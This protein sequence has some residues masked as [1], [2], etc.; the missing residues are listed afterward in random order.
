LKGKMPSEDLTEK[1]LKKTEAIVYSMTPQERVRPETINGSRRR[2]IAVGSGTKPQDVNQLLNQFKQTRKMMRQ[3]TSK[4]G[5]RNIM[6][7][8]G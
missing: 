5:M 3:M 6:K 7:M 8:L 2:R 1:Q 4:K